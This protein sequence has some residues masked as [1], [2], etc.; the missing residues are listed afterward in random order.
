MSDHATMLEH[1]LAEV[2]GARAD[3]SEVRREIH[4]A[5]QRIAVLET[6]SKA[7]AMALADIRALD[8]RVGTL[9]ARELALRPLVT[10]VESLEARQSADD[11][12]KSLVRWGVGVLVAAPGLAALLWKAVTVWAST[13]GQ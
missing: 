2:K 3:V 6:E 13:K 10:K 8:T 11:G 9:E 7:Y 5:I 1:I 12:A 4:E